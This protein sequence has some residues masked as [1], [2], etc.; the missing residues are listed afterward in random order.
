MKDEL[1]FTTFKNLVSR[2]LDL[3]LDSYKLNRVERRVYSLMR[4]HDLTSLQ[5]CL[6]Q[7]KKDSTFREAFIKHFTINTS[8]FYRNPTSFG[9]LEENVLP[10]LFQ[11]LS[12]VNIWSAACSNGAEPYTVA[13]ILEEQGISPQ[14]YRILA[15]DIDRFI[16]DIA[17]EGIYSSQSLLR[18]DKKLVKK[19]F[20]MVGED[21]FQLNPEIKK[22]VQFKYQD[23]L[24]EEF[25]TGWDL[26]ICRNFFIYLTKEG[27]ETLTRRFASVLNKEGILFLGNT[28]FLM[29]PASFNMKKLA[30]SF[31]QKLS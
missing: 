11:R 13:I 3:R 8:E 18:L 22:L 12:K 7:I 21:Q 17:R 14:K 15:T 6:H 4:R 9:Y 1:D 29:D 20:T 28:E 2:E 23:L 19:Y 16:L 5:E 27:K 30:G 24:K 31:Y 26:I 10:S 25:T